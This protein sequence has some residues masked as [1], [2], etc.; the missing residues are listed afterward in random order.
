MALLRYLGIVVGD[1]GDLGSLRV[2]PTLG[3]FVPVGEPLP[4]G[5]RI[6]VE[7]ATYRVTRV[8]EGVVPGC[9]IRAEG[10]A[11]QQLDEMPTVPESV[12]AAQPQAQP[13]EP[14][15]EPVAATPSEAAT[16]AET[17]QA[18]AADA[19]PKAIPAAPSE[20][21]GPKKKGK[22][23]GGKTIIGR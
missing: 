11:G 15:V 1:A 13:P 8:D 2:E 19:V 21:G 22:R 16:A 17:P 5:S 23:K 9:W 14:Q 12:P 20:D 10:A 18:S 6:D 3:R 7:G 4:V